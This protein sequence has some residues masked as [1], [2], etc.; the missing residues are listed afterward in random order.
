MILSDYYFWK[1]YLELRDIPEIYL[2]YLE[3]IKRYSQGILRYPSKIY[4]GNPYLDNYEIFAGIHKD[5]SIIIDTM[6]RKSATL[7]VLVKDARGLNDYIKNIIKLC[8]MKGWHGTAALL[9]IK[10]HP[11]TSD[12]FECVIYAVGY[13]VVEHD[14][15][16]HDE[17]ARIL[18]RLISM[19][20]TLPWNLW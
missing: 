7:E 9:Q 6:I 17:L 19:V 18:M 11:N 14:V 12:I 10:K 16:T 1:E 5:V 20:D 4:T 15:I 13:D 3:T 8:Q 2:E